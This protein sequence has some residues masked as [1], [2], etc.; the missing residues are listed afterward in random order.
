MTSPLAT[1]S[2]NVVCFNMMSFKVFRVSDTLAL[3]SLAGLPSVWLSTL[4]TISS[5][6]FWLV[7]VKSRLS[8]TCLPAAL[9]RFRRTAK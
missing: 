1:A 6:Y 4:F 2:F 5:M 3:G 7:S 8:T 9:S